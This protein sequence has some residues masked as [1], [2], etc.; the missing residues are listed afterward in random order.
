MANKGHAYVIFAQQTWRGR[1]V[2]G[3][4]QAI[5]HSGDSK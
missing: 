2:M 1:Q 4:I 5:S 3:R